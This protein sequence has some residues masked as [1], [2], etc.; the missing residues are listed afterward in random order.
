MDWSIYGVEEEGP[1][2]DPDIDT[3]DIVVVSPS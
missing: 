3:N 2:P 1:I